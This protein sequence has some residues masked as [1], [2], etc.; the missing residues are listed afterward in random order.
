MLVM[1]AT[2]AF[3]NAQQGPGGFYKIP[4]R[5]SVITTP[6]PAE[7]LVLQ[8]DSVRWLKLTRMVMA[9]WKLDTVYKEG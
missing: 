6:L 7:Q 4:S 5:Q 8:T 3:S 2:V 1:T 9:G